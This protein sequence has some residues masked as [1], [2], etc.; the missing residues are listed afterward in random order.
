MPGN[1]S[2]SAE[3]ADAYAKAAGSAKLPSER[4]MIRLLA[5]PISANDRVGISERVKDFHK[6]MADAPVG[7]L[8]Q[9][10]ATLGDNKSGLGRLYKLELSTSLR[11]D[12][13][14]RMRSRVGRNDAGLNSSGRGLG[15]PAKP[16]GGVPKDRVNTAVAPPKA[17]WANPYSIPVG[18]IEISEPEPDGA[19]HHIMTISGSVPNKIEAMRVISDHL[20]KELK[21][22]NAKALVEATQLPDSTGQIQ[23]TIRVSNVGGVELWRGLK[24][25]QG[26]YLDDL[27]ANTVSQERYDDVQAGK[28][29]ANVFQTLGNIYNPIPLIEYTERGLEFTGINPLDAVSALKG[30]KD[31]RKLRG[32]GKI[33]R[34]ALGGLADAAADLKK[35]KALWKGGLDSN[36]WQKAIGQLSDA[37]KAVLKQLSQAHGEVL[38]AIKAGEKQKAYDLVKQWRKPAENLYEEVRKRY[39]QDPEIRKQWADSG[40]DM[41]KN[42]PTFILEEIENGEKTYIKQIVTLEHKTRKYDNPFLAISEKNLAYAFSY[43]NSVIAEDIRRIERGAETVWAARADEIELFVRSVELETK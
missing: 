33:V 19:G 30:L 25:V 32:E 41:S 11:N 24:A 20:A 15:T 28:A 23:P 2:K 34:R 9:I 29:W 27:S 26:S 13:L 16:S 6:L 38:Q 3:W 21:K 39:L 12:L 10:E 18:P 8:K 42:S 43:E 40:A 7:D 36:A 4:E 1:A 22:T 35:V 37:E 17:R 5:L 14:N 31:I